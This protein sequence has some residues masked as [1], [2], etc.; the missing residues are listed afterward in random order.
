[1]PGTIACAAVNA[2]R[3]Y[4]RI[5]GC[6]SSNGF[7]RF[8]M[9]RR[10]PTTTPGGTSFSS[11]RSISRRVA[12]STATLPAWARLL[13]PWLGKVECTALIGRVTATPLR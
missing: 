8:D 2:A 7:M 13:C 3:A 6:A 11:W 1:M 5:C 9:G 10:F 12:R 4:S